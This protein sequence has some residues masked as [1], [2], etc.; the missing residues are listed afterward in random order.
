MFELCADQVAAGGYWAADGIEKDAVDVRTFTNGLPLII[1]NPPTSDGVLR[2][3][4]F[5]ASPTEATQE[6][7][8]Q[9]TTYS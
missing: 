4:K 1:E 3:N 5:A 9:I 8:L 2:L 6:R 7:L